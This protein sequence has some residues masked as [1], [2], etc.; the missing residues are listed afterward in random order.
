MNRKHRH[1]PGSL[2]WYSRLISWTKILLP[3]AAIVLIAAIFLVGREGED[4]IFSAEELATLG[5]GMQLKNP[6]F[7]GTTEDGDPFVLRAVRA[8]PDGPSPDEIQLE[9]PNGTLTMSDGRVLDGSAVSGVML[10]NSGKLTLTEDVTI[11][12]SDGYRAE[13]EFLI[14]DIDAKGAHAPGAVEATGPMGSINADRFRME[15]QVDDQGQPTT[16]NVLYFDGNVHVVFIPE[17]SR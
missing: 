16:D 7:T 17:Q 13:T 14:V 11:T 10:R 5:A 9:S 2:R 8:I 1:N 15:K 6:R 12:T 4:T 3:V